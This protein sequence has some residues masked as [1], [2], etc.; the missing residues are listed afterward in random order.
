[1]LNLMAKAC[2]MSRLP[3][4][5]AGLTQILGEANSNA[6]LELWTPLCEYVDALISFDNWFNQIDYDQETEGSEDIAGV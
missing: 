4:F 5:N 2:K 6:F 3:G 1:M